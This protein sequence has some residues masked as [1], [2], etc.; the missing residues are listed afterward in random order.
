MATISGLGGSNFNRYSGLASGLDVDDLVNSMTYATRN[1]VA[2]VK[3]ELDISNWKTTAY[4]GLSSQ[5]INFSNKYLSYTNSKTALSSS[6]YSSYSVL[7]SGSSS[8]KVKVSTSSASAA[9]AAKNM[10]IKSISSVA[11]AAQFT[12]GAVAATNIVG[13]GRIKASDTVSTVA[14]KTI[15]FSINGGD[16]DTYTFK[17]TAIGDAALTDMVDELNTYFSDKGTDLTASLSNGE[18]N[19]SSGGNDSLSISGGNTNV[20]KTLG[21]SS[22]DSITAGNSLTSTTDTA[23]ASREASLLDDIIRS[24]ITF[25]HN[26]TQKTIKI[27][28][29]DITEFLNSNAAQSI[30]DEDELA[31]NAL[32]YSLQKQLDKSFGAGRVNVGIN[33]DNA[34]E[35]STGDSTSSLK[36]VAA[37][38]SIKGEGTLDVKT[39]SSNRISNSTKLSDITFTNGSLVSDN[40]KFKMTINDVNFNF[41]ESDTIESIMKKINDSD[42][43]VNISYLE[44]TNSFSI[45]SAETGSQSRID[46]SDTAGNLSNI[47]FGNDYAT[48]IKS[49]NDTVMEV[50][51]DGGNTY[52]TITR[53]TA[54]VSLDGVTISLNSKADVGEL[55]NPITFDVSN[56]AEEVVSSIKGMIDE[57]NEIMDAVNSQLTTK[58]SKEY[59]PLTDEQKE[60]MTDEQIEKWE[61]EAKKGVLYGDSNLRQ[62]ANELRNAVS[63]YV[64]DC[65][66]PSVIGVSSSKDMDDNGKI[67]LDEDALKKALEED[68]E[69]VIN[70]FT[71]SST[72]SKS[73][74]YDTSAGIMT[75]VKA[76]MDKYASTTLT[77]SSAR[78]RGILINIAGSENSVTEKDNSMYDT[79]Q[80]LNKQLDSLKT[81][82]KDEE[83]RYYSKFTYLEKYISQ[84]NSY[85]TWLT[86]QFTS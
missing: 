3:Q 47:L 10:S 51:F 7:A 23:A 11:S 66:M 59:P 30:S 53:D 27:N 69:K 76:V 83:S 75:R 65:G 19:I 79:I 5:L 17:T 63:S 73:G 37:S 35:F 45:V 38:N 61:K 34:L 8:D 46:I 44:T 4:R 82:L 31:S 57:Y 84:Q 20:L 6:F 12:S 39:G 1:K 55:E 33:S 26:G 24:T 70:T 9:N 25:S 74:A 64:E 67:V 77:S 42:A 2:K 60:D 29:S 21:L 72:K 36:I 81:K 32:Q 15:G 41:S 80:N 52:Q 62:L 28:E 56:N 54:N 40:G 58:T 71:K 16:S 22:S 18:L 86:S 68:P 13:T 50:S 43:S 14:G 85:S 49:G 48:K 78:S